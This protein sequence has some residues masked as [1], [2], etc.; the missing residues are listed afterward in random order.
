MKKMYQSEKEI[1]KSILEYLGIM[2]I[3]VW[4]NNSGALRTESGGF[5][6]FGAT[7]APDIVGLLPGGQFFGIE[8]K[9]HGGKQTDAQRSFEEAIKKQ[10]GVYI[11]VFSLDEVVYFIESGVFGK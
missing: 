1:L 9:R 10:G 11:L 8:V 5:V 2:K 4:R 6:R 3:F 7:G